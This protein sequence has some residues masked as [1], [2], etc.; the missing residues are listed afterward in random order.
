MTAMPVTPP[1]DGPKLWHATRARD[2]ASTPLRIH[3]R[4]ETS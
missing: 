1:P 3:A 2:D 4:E